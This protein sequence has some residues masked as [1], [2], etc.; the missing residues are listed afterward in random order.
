MSYRERFR[1][2]GEVW[3]VA[4]VFILVVTGIYGGWFS[5]TE[6]AAIGAAATGILA[7]TLGGM[8]LQGLRE[9]LLSTTV[10]TGLIFVVLLGAELFSAALAL[11]RL[12]AELSAVVAGFDVPPLVILLMILLIYFILGCFMESLAMVLLTLPIFI[13]LMLSLDFGMGREQV[14]VWFGILVLMSVVVGMISPPFGL[15]LF[16]INAMAKD[17]PMGETYR[18]VMGFVASDFVRIILLAMVPGLA[19]WLPGLW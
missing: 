12:P 6:G 7:V 8:R 11:S 15:N 16:V 19:L 17:V 5:A 13:P 10:T 9:S 1:A 2:T 18:G 14:L 4:L 3:P